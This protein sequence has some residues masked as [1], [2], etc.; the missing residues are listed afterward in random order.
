GQGRGGLIKRQSIPSIK[1]AVHHSSIFGITYFVLLL[2]LCGKDFMRLLP[3]MLSLLCIPLVSAQAGL[4]IFAATSLTD[5]FESLATAFEAQQPGV[6]LQLN[7]ASSS[8]LAAQIIAGAPADIFASANEKQLELVV[9]DG[10]VDGETARSFAHNQL[11]LALPV[12]NP[13]GIKSPRDLADEGYLLV[14]AAAGT[15]I[16]AYT[17]AMLQSYASEY[18]ADFSRRVRRNLASEESNVRQVV[19]RLALG[20]ADAGIVYQTDALGDVAEQLLVIEIDA[21]H[22]QLAAYPIAPLADSANLDLAMTFIDFVLSDAGRDILAE[23]GFCPPAILEAD[24]LSEANDLPTVPPS[25]AD[26]NTQAQAKR[27]PSPIE[28]R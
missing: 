6:S 14:L 1:R 23:H 12:D 19:A 24:P 8:S 13:A 21:A 28:S 5:A 10:R 4:T 17:D 11:V 26:E 3:L 22:N 7:F 25:F 9:A 18:G 15:P 20:E 2:R 27:C 16:R